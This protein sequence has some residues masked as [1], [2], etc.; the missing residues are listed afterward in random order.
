MPASLLNIALVERA[1]QLGGKEADGTK[2][3]PSTAIENMVKEK[4]RRSTAV[5]TS[6]L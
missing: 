6:C 1:G 4:E 5:G 3:G 2:K